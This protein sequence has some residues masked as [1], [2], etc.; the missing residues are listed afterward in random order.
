MDGWTSWHWK[1]SY[2]PITS[3]TSIHILCFNY[4]LTG[5]EREGNEAVRSGEIRTYMLYK[6]KNGWIRNYDEWLPTWLLLFGLV[7][8]PRHGWCCFFHNILGVHILV[9][10]VWL[11][12]QINCFSLMLLNDIKYFIIFY[13][14]TVR[15]GMVMAKGS[16]FIFHSFNYYIRWKVKIRTTFFLYY[17]LEKKLEKIIAFLLCQFVVIN[18]VSKTFS[19]LSPTGHLFIHSFIFVMFFIVRH[20]GW[21]Y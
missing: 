1:F 18:A 10:G 2:F 13:L 3:N 9:A 12:N 14:I 11:A 17:I 20:I 5:K 6:N 21:N 15:I 8:L 7:L 4:V 19:Y 16:F